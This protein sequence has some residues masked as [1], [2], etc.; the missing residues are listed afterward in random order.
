MNV[1]RSIV[2][3]AVM[4][5]VGASSALGQTQN[6]ETKNAALDIGSTVPLAL[7]LK[8]S[9]GLAIRPDFTFAHIDNGPAFSTWHFGAGVS[10]LASVHQA[11]ALTTYLGARGGYDWYSRSNSPTDWSLAGIFGGR[12]NFDKHFGVSAETGLL[13]QRLSF[14]T[15]P[16][17]S[18][19]EPWTR[20]SGLL[21][22]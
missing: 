22:F 10:A 1:M 3:G 15:G 17:Q 13:Y 19:I 11:G 9:D 16:S 8:V 6:A 14:P 2:I 5:A 20:L 18:A 21:Y 4:I 7:L 12:Y